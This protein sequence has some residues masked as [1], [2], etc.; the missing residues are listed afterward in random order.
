MTMP[1][2]NASP[3]SDWP[4]LGLILPAAGQGAAEAASLYPEGVRFI[5]TVIGLQSMTSEGYGAVIDRIV[6]AARQLADEGASAIVLMGTSLSF[7]KGSAFNLQ[8]RAQMSEASGVPT[9]TMTDA[10]IHGLLELGARSLAVATAYGDEVN[11]QLRV[12]LEQEG[13]EILA[14]RGLGIT[15]LGNQTLDRVTPSALVKFGAATAASAPR[16]QAILVSCGGLRTLHILDPL[17]RRSGLP[18]VSSFPHALRAGVR[19]LGLDGQRQ[20]YGTLLARA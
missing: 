4:V 6:P 17:E 12:Y 10:I 9:L 5:S 3:E 14:L 1:P 19:L 18:V 11:G 16:A 20:S 2:K 13:F 15:S 8:M 7:F